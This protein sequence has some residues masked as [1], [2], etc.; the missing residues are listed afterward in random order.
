MIQLC[1][2]HPV[3]E[4]LVDDYRQGRVDERYDYSREYET[5]AYFFRGSFRCCFNF[6]TYY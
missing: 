6:F 3:L 4:C 2:L 1:V 5:T